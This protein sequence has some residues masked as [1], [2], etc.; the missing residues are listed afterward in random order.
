MSKNYELIL[1]LEVFKQ[2]RFDHIFVFIIKY[3]SLQMEE[4]MGT[5]R[6]EDSS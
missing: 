1:L 3:H 6:N 2:E 5:S 4:D